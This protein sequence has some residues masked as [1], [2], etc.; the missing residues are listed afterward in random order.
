M[1]AV[2]VA[3][4]PVCNLKRLRRVLLVVVKSARTDVPLVVRIPYLDLRRAAEVESRV[5][6]NGEDSPVSPHLEVLVVLPR[7]ERVAALES[8][9]ME[10]AVP[11]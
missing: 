1:E 5:A 7:R 2:P 8:V 11:D 10:D 3:D 9:K 6:R 4:L